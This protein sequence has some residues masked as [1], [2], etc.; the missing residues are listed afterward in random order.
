[1]KK[2]LF[3]LCFALSVMV[4]PYAGSFVGDSATAENKIIYETSSG[5]YAVSSSITEEDS[6]IYINEGATVKLLLDYE[7]PEFDLHISEDAAIDEATALLVDYRTKVRDYYSLKNKAALS[8]FDLPEDTYFSA[9]TPFVFLPEN[10]IDIY[11]GTID[12]L[13]SSDAVKTVFVTEKADIMENTSFEVMNIDSPIVSV[14]EAY[15]QNHLA[16]SIVSAGKTGAGVN[17]GVY[18]FGIVDTSNSN[19]ASGSVENCTTDSYAAISDHT[20]GVAAII[21]GS[22][23]IARNAKIYS[24]QRPATQNSSDVEWLLNKGVHVINNSW[25][26]ISTNSALNGYNSDS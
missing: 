24:K 18:E 16:S 4:S 14:T 9:Y 15:Y 8:E 7:M 20:T 3:I 26:V 1:M 13:A 25:V 10:S 23:G 22:Q 19:F 11:D 5:V 17:V 21:N 12:E 6:S 2:I